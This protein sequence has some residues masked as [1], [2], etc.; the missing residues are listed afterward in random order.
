VDCLVEPDGDGGGTTND[1]TLLNCGSISCWEND[2]ESTIYCD[3]SECE[4]P[5]PDE[6]PNPCPDTPQEGWGSE[7]EGENFYQGIK[8]HIEATNEA[9]EGLPSDRIRL[10]ACYGNYSGPHIYDADFSRILPTLLDATVGTLVLEGANPRHEGDLIAV[11]NHVK[12]HG[13]PTQRIAWGVIDVKTPIVETPE[14]VA[15]RLQLLADAGIDPDNITAGTD[16]GFETFMGFGNVS[17]RVAKEKL[18][19]A[20][21]GA[22]LANQWLS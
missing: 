16:C 20:A 4:E 6:E 10:H 5:P 11:K 8:T 15:M 13:A 9:I 1:S 14:T 12:E 2:I 7:Y 18:R 21:R 19:S 17:H 22:E 3:V